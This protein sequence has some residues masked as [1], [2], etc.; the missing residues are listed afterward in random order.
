MDDIIRIC[1]HYIETDSFDSLKEYIF[2]LFNENQDWPYLFQK[3]YLHACLKQ[4]EQIA[5]WL[6]NDIFPSMDAIQQIAL[7]QI[8][9]YGKYLL[10]KAPKA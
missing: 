7:R 4:K 5:K 6:Q 9:P 8:F 10:S 3:V 2:S 1:K